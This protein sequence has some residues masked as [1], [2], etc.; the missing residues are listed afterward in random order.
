MRKARWLSETEQTAWRAYREMQLLLNAAI[1]RDLVD[2]GLSDAD[3]D[4]LSTL[5]E[6][7]NH[8][9]RVTDLAN[10][11]LWSS[12]RISHH[13]GRMEKRG[14]IKRKSSVEDGRGANVELTHAG[15]RLIEEVAP[16]HV[17]SVRRRFLDPL[18]AA[19]LRALT[20]IA[21]SVSAHLRSGASQAQ[22]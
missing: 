18:D 10:D 7:Q 9:S 16:G 19:D 2:L 15:L 8:R 21:H 17:E 4:V 5:S 6:A 14:L 3:Y 12:S 11:L 1:A 20:E 22:N 13:L